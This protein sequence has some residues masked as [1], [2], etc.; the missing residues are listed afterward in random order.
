MRADGTM[1]MRF[2]PERE[3]EYDDQA[4]P[5]TFYSA[6][7]LLPPCHY[8][9]RASSLPWPPHVR[10]PFL[11]DQRDRTAPPPTILVQTSAPTRLPLAERPLKARSMANSFPDECSSFCQELNE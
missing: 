6:L 2:S 11:F 1:A 8:L 4:T 5:P 7:A 9:F 10:W 3:N